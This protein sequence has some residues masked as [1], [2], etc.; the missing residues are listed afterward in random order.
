MPVVGKSELTIKI[1]EFPSD[2]QTLENGW[3]YLEIECEGRIVSVQ[4]KPKMFKKLEEAKEQYPLWVAAIRGTLGA[5]TEK[6]YVL[7]QPSIQ[8]FERQAKPEKAAS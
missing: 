1:N 3:K 2:V 4:L 8:V 6:G 7:E 5:I